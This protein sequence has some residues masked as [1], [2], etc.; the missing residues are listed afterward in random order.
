MTRLAPFVL[1]LS[2]T[3]A[4]TSA[5]ANT[6][7]LRQYSADHLKSH[8][9]QQV[10]VIALSFASDG[11]DQV[12]LDLYVKLRPGRIQAMGT[13]YCDQD[14]EG[15]DCFM[16]GDAGRFSLTGAANGALRLSVAL[17]GISF[18]TDADFITISGTSGDDRV[19]LLP[20]LGRSACNRL[21]L[22]QGLE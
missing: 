17:R 12:T 16:E 18:E 22:S 6:C 20:P 2:L 8:P 1:A 19:F 15:L 5:D 13:A 4:A 9:T 3:L 10:T 7:Y 14:G 11:G 21:S